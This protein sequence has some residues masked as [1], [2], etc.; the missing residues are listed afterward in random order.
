MG[1]DANGNLCYSQVYTGLG[2]A[3]GQTFF[4]EAVHQSMLNDY[5][6]ELY[7]RL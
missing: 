7:L 5:F 6:S 2:P 3:E 1:V 4:E